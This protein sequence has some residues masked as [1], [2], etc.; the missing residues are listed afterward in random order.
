MKSLTTFLFLA[1]S[2][3]TSYFETHASVILDFTEMSLNERDKFSQ[4]ISDFNSLQ[5]EV[6]TIK[7]LGFSKNK[8][9]DESFSELT[10]ILSPEKFTGL[11]ILDLSNNLLTEKAVSSILPWL[12][13]NSLQYVNLSGNNQISLRNVKKLFIKLNELREF[14]EAEEFMPKIVFIS[15]DYVTK[16]NADAKIYGT[17]VQEKI[18]PGNWAEIHRTFYNSSTYKELLKNRKL[19][20]YDNC[21]ESMKRL[22]HLDKRTDEQLL[23]LKSSD[24][25]LTDSDSISLSNALKVMSPA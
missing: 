7:S 9:G 20:Q 23:R 13:L 21:L 3:T 15:K 5:E 6:S 17:L 19:N 14:T 4:F 1:L 10:K 2:S 11:E 22:R 8:L 25:D 18:I 24:L 12:Q 16:A